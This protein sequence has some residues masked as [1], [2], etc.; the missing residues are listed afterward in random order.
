M[1]AGIREQQAMM[2]AASGS[3]SQREGVARSIRQQQAAVGASVLQVHRSQV[4]PAHTPR[5]ARTFPHAVTGA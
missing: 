1:H 5:H 3:S 4:M 2:H